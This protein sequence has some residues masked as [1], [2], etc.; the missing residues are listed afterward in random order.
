[1]SAPNVI[2]SILFGFSSLFL[3][4]RNVSPY[5]ENWFLQLT[6]LMQPQCTRTRYILLALLFC[7][8]PLWTYGS[9]E[10]APAFE[11]GQSAGAHVCPLQLSSL[12]VST[13][14]KVRSLKVQRERNLT[15]LLTVLKAPGQAHGSTIY[16]IYSSDPVSVCVCEGR[17]VRVCSFLLRTSE[18]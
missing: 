14:H 12:D 11:T 6:P 8:K 5:S 15:P 13:L 18:L 16:A 1:M 2:M 3:V 10:K 7:S 4:L 17:W 9:L